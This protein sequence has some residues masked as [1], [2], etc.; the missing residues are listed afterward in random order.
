M[1]RQPLSDV[2]VLDLSH[3]LSGPFATMTLGDFGARVI[4]IEAPSGDATRK[5]GP[6]F[7]NDDAA[8]FYAINRNKE[9]VTLD[10]KDPEG[11]RVFQQLV[12]RA[13]IVVE[14]FRP[15]T[16]TKLGFD[17]SHLR[18]LNSR[19]I[20]CSISGFGQTGPRRT[21]TGFDQIAQGMS[22]LMSVTG[23]PGGEP[24]RAGYSVG[25]LSAAM[26]ALVGIL[27]ALRHRDQT[28]EGQW[29]DVSLLDSLIS[30]QTFQAQNYFA[31]GHNP[32]PGGSAHPN[33]VPYQAFHCQDGYVNIAVG[34]DNLW[35]AF[36]RALDL[37]LAD[38]PRYRTNAD[39]FAHKQELVAIIAKRLATL[40]VQEALTRFEEFS[41][42]AGPVY[43]LSEVFDDPQVRA[44]ELLFTMDVENIGTLH[45]INTPVKLSKTPPAARS[46]PP[47]MGEHT[48]TVCR[49]MSAQNPTENH[50]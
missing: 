24:L 7:L 18:D 3:I 28:N 8:Y 32:E 49:E 13:D 23:D 37:D 45:Q 29:V 31:T 47:R 43:R 11:R 30:F 22:G 42:P 21:Q 17:F 5:W 1:P 33:L 9:S 4:K 20:L 34:N 38:N 19:I 27:I 50:Q 35:H 46:A 26:W 6:P 2:T 48:D 40:S 39:R 16:L 36:C 10:L 44:R 14:N 25:D 15:G 12:K 41:V